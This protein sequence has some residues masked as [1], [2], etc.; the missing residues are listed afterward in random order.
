MTNNQS[1]KIHILHTGLVKVDKALPFHGQFRNPLAFTGLFRSEKNQVVL[2]VSSYLIEHPK[3]LILIDT[4]WNKLVR[5]SNWKELGPQVQINTGYLPQGWSIDERLQELGYK[6]SDIDYLL[7]SHMHCDHVSGLKQV[8]DAKNILVSQPEWKI[9][10]RLPMVY[11]PHEW[12]GVTVQT[13]QYDHSNIGPFD[14]SFDLFGDGSIV[15]IHTPGHAAGMS[16]TI[17]KGS[18]D[19]YVLLAADTGYAARS[20]EKMITPGICTSRKDAITSLGWIREQAHSKDCIAAIANHD[21]EVDAQIIEL[22]Y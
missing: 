13:Y 8:K 12:K 5:Q 22:P 14:E 16:A 1:I 7:L 9:A 10:N 20:W 6:P 19:K 4:G 11:L 21:P 2:P 17:I 3:G 15:Q 18:D